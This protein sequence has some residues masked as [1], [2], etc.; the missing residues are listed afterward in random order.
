MSEATPRADE[1]VLTALLLATVILAAITLMREGPQYDNV[2]ESWRF[3]NTAFF[4][5]ALVGFLGWTQTFRIVPTL[6][7][8][9]ADRQPWIAA[10]ALG[11]IFTVA[12]S[13]LNRSYT[14]PTGRMLVAEIDTLKEVKE[15]RWQLS[16]KHTDGSYQRYQ[17]KKDTA[18]AL[19]NQ[20]NV[21]MEVGRGALGFDLITD[22]AANP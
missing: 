14:T 12:G 20:K 19:Q 5:G 1:K 2:L 16:V 15:D 9:P 3:F 18:A 22:F 21:R 10:F 11:L 17:I 4:T 6:S 7:L 8:K 13:W